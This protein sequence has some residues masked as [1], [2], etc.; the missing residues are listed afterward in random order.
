MGL[1]SVVVVDV[2]F[3]TQT[4]LYEEDGSPS[5]DCLMSICPSSFSLSPSV[6]MSTRYCRVDEVPG[7]LEV[8][9][10]DDTRA[11]SPLPLDA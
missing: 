9:D 6:V 10:I 2:M 8:K 3:D 1:S 11:L 5:E 7:M 4:S